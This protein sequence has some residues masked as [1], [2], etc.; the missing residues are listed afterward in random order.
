MRSSQRRWG[1]ARSANRKASPA[2]SGST[3]RSPWYVRRV[4]DAVLTGA[5]VGAAAAIVGGAGT[6]LLAH[7]LQRK[8][9]WQE[10]LRDTASQL[11]A[12]ARTVNTIA[13]RLT[14]PAEE[15]PTID[16]RQLLE[17]PAE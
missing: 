17:S 2:T 12:Q 6:Q 4:P 7:H 13:L 3:V 11:A 8:T 16:E 5:L 1:V 14:H 9:R 15:P 10:P